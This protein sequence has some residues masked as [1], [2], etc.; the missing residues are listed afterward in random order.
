MISGLVGGSSGFERQRERESPSR[1]LTTKVKANFFL[2]TIFHAFGKG[3]SVDFK[4]LNVLRKT[5]V[6]S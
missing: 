6:F 4:L 5:N 2:C 1:Y 3:D